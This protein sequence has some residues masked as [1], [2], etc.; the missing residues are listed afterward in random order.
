MILKELS[1]AVYQSKGNLPKK[2]SDYLPGY[3][4]EQYSDLAKEIHPFIEADNF[5]LKYADRSEHY[6]KSYRI[7]EVCERA[8]KV[9]RKTTHPT[10]LKIIEENPYCLFEEFERWVKTGHGTMMSGI[11]DEFWH[12][13]LTFSYEY[14]SWCHD[15]Y[16]RYIHHVPTPS[17]ERNQVTSKDLLDNTQSFFNSYSKQFEFTETVLLYSLPARLVFSEGKSVE[18]VI[19]IIKMLALNEPK[20]KPIRLKSVDQFV[21]YVEEGL[22]KNGYCHIEQE[23]SFEQYVAINDHLGSIKTISDIKLNNE[24]KLKF[25]KPE[26][27]SSH[28]DS[29]LVNTVAWYCIRQDP[30][31]GSSVLVDCKPIIEALPESTRKILRKTH[32]G[33]PL[34]KRF[35]TDTYP[36]LTPGT[37][38]DEIYYTHWLL[39]DNYS[40]KQIAALQALESSISEAEKTVLRLK[41]GEALFVD[42]K[43]MLHGRDDIPPN[44]PRYL[45]RIHTTKN[46][47]PK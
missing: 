5:F 26:S 25:N 37:T 7:R 43:R 20:P 8:L 41:P 21:T 12:Q 38:S 22:Q 3:L 18:E 23:L 24:S 14:K 11:I 15:N 29:P 10:I 19:E 17:Y 16:G 33:F 9:L 27:L 31:V 35:K 39:L 34:Y 46:N 2:L 42:N 40:E 30:Q 6:V 32:I 45:Y 1:F 13:F 4:P 47:P 44:S 36:I 28:T